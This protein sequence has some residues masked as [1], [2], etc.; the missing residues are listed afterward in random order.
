MKNWGRKRFDR[1]SERWP[2]DEKGQPV[3]PALFR[4]VSGSEL[5]VE[6]AVNL[7]EA[8][9]IPVLRRPTGDGT[10]GQVVIGFSGAGVDLM[11]PETMLED[12]RNISE[13]DAE[14]EPEELK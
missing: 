10:L 3:S 2:L 12:A 4:H 14:N 6:M 9:G 7:L 1:I 13:Y 8:Y 5:D 11:V